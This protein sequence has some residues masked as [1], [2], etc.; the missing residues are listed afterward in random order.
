M[1][2]N[3]SEIVWILMAKKLS[4]HATS[5][6]LET[7][8]TYLRENPGLNYSKEILQDFWNNEPVE[9]SQYAEIRYKMLVQKMK[10]QGVETGTTFSNDHFIQAE[11][12]TSGSNKKKWL[13]FS[14]VAASFIAIFFLISIFKNNNNTKL[15][16]EVQF[17]SE[18]STKPGSKTK[19]LLPDGT[20]V[21]LNSSSV[22]TYDKNYGNSI[23]EVSLTG[24]AYFDVI[25]NASKPFII[26]TAKMDIK[27]LG[28][29]FNVKCYPG[30]KTTETSLI[31]GSIEVTLRDRQEKIKMKPNEKLVIN[32]DEK[33]LTKHINNT[34]QLQTI[35]QKP[36]ITLSH[37]SVLPSDSTVIETAWVQNRLLFNSETFEDVALK[38]ERWYGVKIKF[39]NEP[40]KQKRFTGI[41]DK[42]SV[43]EAL[44]ALQFST[45]NTFSYQIKN[46]EIIISKYVK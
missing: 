22:I 44:D 24:E 14:S 8:E 5:A 15:A 46:D 23:R 28:T 26:H 29:A 19:L 2:N 43:T 1:D 39:T 45:P 40:I 11:M 42:E 20:K 34:V 32:N 4:G 36:F 30:E 21:W 6:E 41:F 37:L 17:K 9:N 10:E 16:S 25:K 38:M 7:L 31:R 33:L 18:I 13:I 35:V 3:S 12:V 27:V